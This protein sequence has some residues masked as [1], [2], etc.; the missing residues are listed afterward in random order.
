ME[1]VPNSLAL[2]APVP[3]LTDIHRL[4]EGGRER[5]PYVALDRNE[6]LSP[7]PDWALAA[8]RAGIDSAL[9]TTYPSLDGLYEDLSGLLD[10]PRE[11]L[12]LTA[13]SDAAFR[14]LLQAYVRPGDQVVMLD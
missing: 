8:I 2:P 1:S 13:G 9:L 7:L 14:P 11:R 6:R 3:A 4:R 12:L 10:T 5:S